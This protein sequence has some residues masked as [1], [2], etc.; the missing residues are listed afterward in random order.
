[1]T[2]TQPESQDFGAILDAYERE[3]SQEQPSSP[4][5]QGSSREA[6]RGPKVGDR[7]KGKLARLGEEAA[8]VDLAGKAEGMIP[9]GELKDAEG[10][11]SLAVGDKVEAQVVA[12]DDEAGSIVLRF[13]AGKRTRTAAPIPA[14]ISQAHQ[15]GIPIEGTVTEAVKGGFS[16]MVSGVRAFCPVSQLDSRPVGDPATWIG[17]RLSFRVLRYEEA[18][19][20]TNIVLS[21]R[22]L[23]EDEAKEK[24]AETR[25][26]LAPG[27][28]VKGKVSSLTSFGAF[29]DLGGLEGLLHIGE[30]AYGRV[31]HPS[32]L[33]AEGDEVE[34]KVLAIDPP[35]DGKGRERI[36]L[37]RRALLQDPWQ[38]GAAQLKAG[39]Q[40]F[41][42]VVRLQP[43]G[44]FLELAPGVDG[45]LHVSELSNE[46]NVRHPKDVL[47]VG[48]SI[49]V[50]IRSIDLGQK[51][52]SLVRP[53]SE[54][55]PSVSEPVAMASN[56]ASSGS[57]FGSLGDF[58]KKAAVKVR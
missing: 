52:I 23:L 50:V 2:E 29:I 46:R 19:G 33:L 13:R 8:F 38:A 28:V 43:F 17:R 41:A 49:E 53:G 22:A 44:A 55:D 10:N 12:I 25:A 20:R 37:S 26:T 51:R 18:K 42:K 35:K 45:L 15:A 40:Q 5:E 4:E 39:T 7:V 58:F 14:E 30:L 16:V 54:S 57:G 56:S 11:I 3:T 27:K 31:E 48:Q 24:A 34:V 32:E 9:I 1:M 36:S 21:R 47:K 6:A